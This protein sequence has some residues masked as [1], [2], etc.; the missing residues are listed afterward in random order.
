[1]NISMHMP[2]QYIGDEGRKGVR[3]GEHEESQ[4]GLT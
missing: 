2:T 4:L 3:W 1:M